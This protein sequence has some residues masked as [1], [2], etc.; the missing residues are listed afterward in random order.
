MTGSVH[1]GAVVLA[2]DL[3]CAYADFFLFWLLVPSELCIVLVSDLGCKAES[4]GYVV[5]F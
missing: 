2:N 5:A 3:V 1:V 4:F